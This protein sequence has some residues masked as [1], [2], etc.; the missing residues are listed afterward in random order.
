M[1]LKLSNDH[2][3]IHSF[4]FDAL[5]ISSGA[6]SVAFVLK[7]NGMDCFLEKRLT[8]Q[9]FS[10]V[11]G[12]LDTPAS[13]IFSKVSSLHVKACCKALAFSVIAPVLKEKASKVMVPVSGKVAAN[14]KLWYNTENIL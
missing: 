7:E 5:G 13:S 11:A 14:W 8:F 10:L 3:V 4:S 6:P 2:S 9:E 12:F 1:K